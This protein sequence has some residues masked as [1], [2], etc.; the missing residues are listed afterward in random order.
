MVI[1][2]VAGTQ[3]WLTLMSYIIFDVMGHL[4]AVSRLERILQEFHSKQRVQKL[5]LSFVLPED[6]QK[7]W[8]LWVNAFVK[9]WCSYLASRRSHWRLPIFEDAETESANSSPCLLCFCG[10]PENNMRDRYFKFHSIWLSVALASFTCF[11]CE[12]SFCRISKQG[13]VYLFKIRSEMWS[14]VN[15]VR[16]FH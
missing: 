16:L 13:S 1:D 6:L 5:E 9:V 8:S 10:W 2:M 15:K 7:Q 3:T 11:L 14:E 4:P 12:M